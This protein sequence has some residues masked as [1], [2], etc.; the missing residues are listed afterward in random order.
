MENNRSKFRSRTAH[1]TETAEPT[2][3]AHTEAPPA[4]DSPEQQP[5]HGGSLPLDILS[6]LVLPFSLLY[7]EILAKQRIFGSP[8]DQKFVYLG[9]FS[10]FMG[11]LLSALTMLLGG[12]GRR[13]LTRVFLAALG[14][15]FSF[16]VSYQNNF[17]TLFSWQTLG[18]AKDIVE[19]WKEALLAALGV[20][21]LILAFFL[22]LVLMGIFGRRLMADDRPRSLPLAAMGAVLSLLPYSFIMTLFYGIHHG[23]SNYMPQYYYQYIQSDLDQTVSYYGI[24]NTTRLEIKQ[25]LFGAPVEEFE[26]SDVS[27]LIDLTQTVSSSD[28]SA[29]DLDKPR[30]YGDN[31][32]DIDFVRAEES[33]KVRTLQSMDKYFA[34][35]TPTKQN[36][37]TGYFEGKNLIFIT[38][39]GY[40]YKVIDPEFT[41]TLYKMATEGF[42]FNNFYTSLWGGSTATGEYSNMTGNFYVTANCLKMSADTYQPFALGNQFSK[43][44][45]KTVAYHNNSYT[46]YGRD[47]SHPNFGYDYTGIGNG[48]ELPHTYWPNSDKEMAEVTADDYIGTGEKFHAYYMSVSGHANYSTTG[49]AMANLHY[50]ELPEKYKKCSYEVKSYLACQY[51]VELMLQVLVQK[52][53][54][55]G[56]LE[57]TVFAMTADHFPYALSNEA[58][59]ELYHLEKDN[60]RKNSD[61]YR[62]SFI[63][64]CA[65]MPEPVVVDK[66]CSSIDILPTLS[67]LFGLEYDSRVIMGSDILCDG[68]HFALVKVNGWSWVSTQG[69]YIA[70]WHKFK[71]NE[72]CTLTEEEQQQYVDAIN[73]RVKAMTNYSL[74]ILERDYYRHIFP[75]E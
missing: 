25:L 6:L 37:Y 63:L 45:Y 66:P 50:A 29:T 23:D 61:L 31:V 71:P 36:E 72:S 14:V 20:W 41:P 39:E 67:N 4:A 26:F 9:V 19:F 47:K 57:D 3:A 5:K 7:M 46:Y 34:S 60:I 62:N 32:M 53:D 48:M 8:F 49:N 10:A 22:P 68:D 27:S 21:Y 13:I 17:Q 42:V 75:E 2:P 35:L 65:S 11:F 40:S 58:L 43:I 73:L 70:T 52:L 28:V 1:D 55:A 16:H 24:L 59:A 56:I 30:E 74:Q 12:K 54:E 15:L 51:E 18:Q 38:L 33:T 69:E 44:G 64:W